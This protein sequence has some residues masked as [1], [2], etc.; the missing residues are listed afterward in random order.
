M[1]VEQAIRAQRAS[2]G[3]LLRRA[4]VV[5][6]AVGNK[7]SKSEVAGEKAVVVLVERSCR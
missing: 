1:T 4:N 3:D 6:V 5:G 2:Q 7:G